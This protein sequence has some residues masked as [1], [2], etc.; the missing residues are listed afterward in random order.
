VENGPLVTTVDAVCERISDDLIRQGVPAGEIA[1]VSAGTGT[2]RFDPARVDGGP[3]RA[4]LRLPPHAP[5]GHPDR[6]GRAQ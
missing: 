5:S 6:C 3:V 2:E 4:E 1:V